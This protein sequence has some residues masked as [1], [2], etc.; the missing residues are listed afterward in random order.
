MKEYLK[1][2][3][4]MEKYKGQKIFAVFNDRGIRDSCHGKL[5]QVMSR[6]LIIE[7][8][9]GGA[10]EASVHYENIIFIMDRRGDKIF[11]L[12]DLGPGTDMK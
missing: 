1:A 12:K 2:M 11:A 8:Y 9:P 4:K 10:M 7:T 6:I 5:V 3:Q